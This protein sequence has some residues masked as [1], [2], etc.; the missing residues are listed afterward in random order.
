VTRRTKIER[1]FLGDIE[2]GANFSRGWKRELYHDFMKKCDILK[3][4]FMKRRELIKHLETN[5]CIL[6]REGKKHSVYL[7]KLKNKVR[8]YKMTRA[9]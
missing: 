8:H 6:L 1:G 5:K 4:R 9:I 2:M 3:H 7:N